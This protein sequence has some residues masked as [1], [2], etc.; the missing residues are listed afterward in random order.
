MA[1]KIILKK[2]AVT[3]KAPVAGD[4]SYGELALNYE[5]GKLYFKNASN[6]IK[7]FTIDDSVVTL[8]GT[9]TLTN[10]T[11][12][13]PTI[14]GGTI[15]NVVI[16]GTTAAAGSFTT[17][18]GSGIVSG[19]ELTSTNASGDEG[20]QINLAK[21]PN[22][23]I[24]GGVTIDVWQN[25]LRFF[26]Q[27]G[28]ARGA[29]IDLSGTSAGV[30]TNLVS[31]GGGGTVT[32]VGLTVPTG[33]TVT[34]SPI[35][36][37][38]TLAITLTSG[39]SIPTTASQTNWDTAYTDR[40][41][42][43]GGSTGLT[44]STG[45]TSL[46]ATTLGSNLFTITNP[47]AVT[48]PRFNADNTVSALSAA[49]F[50]TAIGAGTSST[51]GTVT[52]VAVSVPTGLSVSGSPI[53]SSGTIAITLA[54]GYS[55]PTTASQT[56][57]DTA[58]TDRNKW[59]GGSTG[60]TASTGR[61]SLGA[62][63]VGGNL[64]T[65]T[66]PTAVTFLR[67][68]ADNTVSTLDAATFRTAI[69]AGTGSGTVTGVTATSPV[70][71]SGGTAP[72][73]SLSAGYGDTQ[74]PF[75][76]KTANYVL[77]APN[78]SAGAPTF[79]A[80]VAADIPSLSSTYLPLSGGTVTGTLDVS[81]NYINAGGRMSYVRDY[82]V[83]TATNVAIV[84]DG[85]TSTTLVAGSIYQV[86]LTTT[87]TGTNTGA[88]YIVYQTAAST[89]V[90]KLVSRQ[91]GTSNNPSLAISGTTMVVSHAHA[92]TYTIRAVIERFS[93]GNT[94]LTS[95]HYL[96]I[97]SILTYDGDTSAVSFGTKAASNITTLGMSGQ[98]T[99]TVAV[100]TAPMVITSTT[101]VANLNVATAGTAD[102]LTTTRTLWGQNFNGSANVTGALSSV[103]TLSMSG[104]LTNTVAIG[105]APMVITSTTRVANLN[106]ATAGTADTLTTA[107][108]INGTSFNGSANITVP[109]NTSQSSSDANY[110]IP[111]V[112]GVT[113]GNQ[114]LLTDS[115]A[116]FTYNPSSNTLTV[117]VISG[118]TI[119][120]STAIGAPAFS[121]NNINTYSVVDNRYITRLRT[122]GFDTT[123][124]ASI[125]VTE[126]TDAG[127]YSQYRTADIA[128]Q[129]ASS[130]MSPGYTNTLF[131]SATANGSENRISGDNYLFNGSSGS[132]YRLLNIPSTAY[133]DTASFDIS[134]T[135]ST[136]SSKISA[137]RMVG[138][139][140]DPT[141]LTSTYWENPSTKVAPGTM[142][143][144]NT[145]DTPGLY[146]YNGTSWV[147]LS[148]AGGG[149]GGTADWYTIMADAG[150]TGASAFASTVPMPSGFSSSGSNGRM[151]MI[152]FVS[153][154]SMWSYPWSY[155]GSTYG[156][157]TI[158]NRYYA[159]SMN[160]SSLT[161]PYPAYNMGTPTSGYNAIIMQYPQ[162]HSFMSYMDIT[163]NTPNSTWS[164]YNGSGYMQYYS[165]PPYSS[166]HMYGVIVVQGQVTPTANP[167]L[168]SLTVD[169]Y[170]NSY[171]MSTIIFFS[172]TTWADV[173]NAL[174][175]MSNIV[176]WMNYTNYIPWTWIEY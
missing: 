76:S 86:Y 44:A 13:S 31:A 164:S 119:T 12:T 90:A 120:A 96:G 122:P 100:G 106:V 148:A 79:R 118:E 9:Q 97:D 43:N 101:R 139:T 95:P 18:T 151:A 108:T 45:R 167:A 147:A 104:Q 6:V 47:S 39:Y 112:N 175:G 15:N 81:G 1:N 16:G 85:G 134:G 93:T 99:N 38:G 130:A 133:V 56:N 171:A 152:E 145:D 77:A 54:A 113:A 52:S 105:T 114:S 58:Y 37:S 155:P 20:G 72:V 87:G 17:V 111:F 55:I 129:T 46:G 22:A 68:N 170:Y 7:S 143:V 149:G 74:N 41:N 84:T 135:Q 70:A 73:I 94:T 33:L 60:L 63:T 92:S 14:T 24:A 30:G 128:V 174:M 28:D 173:Q 121:A 154:S 162:A 19:S 168:M 157:P 40:L 110:V 26:V 163:G 4:L 126:G 158:M 89:W 5:D 102:T 125:Y 11:L 123:T 27:G 50:R 88:K 166:G 91:S 107:R 36:T 78:G 75:A 137:I 3:N 160:W 176:S 32:S 53:T 29:Y 136:Y 141:T 51:S 116:S 98:L 156:P 49:D 117:P 131:L 109:V 34:G 66:N 21:P 124:G 146:W 150:T 67:I 42:W 140:A 57:W 103:T 59:D 144:G 165:L 153:S 61:T 127:P 35:T 71:S 23:T 82:S 83:A 169:S 48:F 132:L 64:F 172:I 69:G 8:T 115:V 142:I 10:K 80:L 62:T 2:S 138:V 159:D 25:R 161:N 65:L